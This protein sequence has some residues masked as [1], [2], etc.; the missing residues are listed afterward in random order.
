MEMQKQGTPWW[1]P[2]QQNLHKALELFRSESLSRCLPTAVPAVQSVHLLSDGQALCIK[3]AKGQKGKTYLQISLLKCIAV[4]VL[5]VSQSFI[6]LTF[7]QSVSSV[8]SVSEYMA[9]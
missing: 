6:H 5:D 4:P 8:K 1:P 3:R 2:A 9:E 7:L